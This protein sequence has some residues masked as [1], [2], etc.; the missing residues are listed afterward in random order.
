MADQMNYGVVIQA[1]VSSTRL[2][3][4]VLMDIEGQPMLLRQASRLREGIGYGVPLIIATSDGPE[5]DPI[6]ALCEEYSFSCFRGPL[7]DV[8]Q[9]FILCAE[10]NGLEYIVRVGGDDP[11]VDPLCCTT[12]IS[13]HQREPHDFMYASNR[14]GWPYGCAAELISLRALQKIH[15]STKDPFYREHTIPYFFDHMG[16]FDLLKVK[17]PLVINRPDYY[18]TVDFSEDIE[19]IRTLFRLLANEGDYFPLDRVIQLVDENPVI[20]R[21]NQ[22]LHEG[23]DH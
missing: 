12:L 1:R 17:A 23:F 7:D 14:E 13:M 4:K 2:P 22:H 5:D 20:C 8:V 3:G 9:R 15:T 21:I 19:L 11:L 6:E 10:E 18:F 16:E